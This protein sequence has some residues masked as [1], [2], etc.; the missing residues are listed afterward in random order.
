[1][2]AAKEVKKDKEKKDKKEKKEKKE[3]KGKSEKDD[4]AVEAAQAVP[5]K[6]EPAAN[7]DSTFEAFLESFELGDNDTTGAKAAEAAEAAKAEAQAEEGAPAA[8]F[9]ENSFWEALE[10]MDQE[11]EQVPENTEAQLPAAT[12]T[13]GVCMLPVSAE[14]RVELC[15]KVEMI[16]RLSNATLKLGGSDSQALLKIGGMARERDAA[17]RYAQTILARRVTTVSEHPDLTLLSVSSEWLEGWKEDE[18]LEQELGVLI[19]KLDETLVRGSTSKIPVGTIVEARY[20]KGPRWFLAS[21]LGSDGPNAITVRWHIDSSSCEVG[22]KEIR[23]APQVG[24]FGPPRARLA[25]EVRILA[26]FNH[27]CKGAIAATL[28]VRPPAGD[29]GLEVVELGIPYKSARRLQGNPFVA[30]LLR[31]TGLPK[32]AEFFLTPKFTPGRRW[33]EPSVLLAGSRNQRWL[34][35]ALLVAFA[36]SFAAHEFQALPPA[37]VGDA[38][39][40][41]VPTVVMDEINGRRC[42]NMLSLMDRTG[43]FI[44]PMAQKR[45]KKREVSEMDDL[46]DLLFENTRKGDRKELAVFGPLRNRY[47]AKIAIM[48]SIE[49]KVPGFHERGPDRDSVVDPSVGLGVDIVWLNKAFEKASQLAA[50]TECAADAAGQIVLLAGTAEE[51]ARAR[52]YLKMIKAEEEGTE[53][54]DLE[55][56]NDVVTLTVPGE[57]SSSK[58]LASQWQKFAEETKTLAFYDGWKGKDGAKRIVLLGSALRQNMARLD[59]LHE[60]R[61]RI[62][63]AQQLLLDKEKEET[64]EGQDWNSWGGDWSGGWNSSSWPGDDKEKGGKGSSKGDGGRRDS[65]ASGKGDSFGSDGNKGKGKGKGKDDWDEGK[66]KGKGD[67][68]GFKAKGKGQLNF[69]N[70]GKGGEETKTA[71]A[72]ADKVGVAPPQTPAGPVGPAPPRTPGGPSGVA[73]PMTPG[74]PGIFVAPPMTPALPGLAAPFTPGF[75]PTAGGQ[76]APATP[77]IPT[78]GGDPAKARPEQPGLAAREEPPGPKPKGFRGAPPPAAARATRVAVAPLLVT[79]G[80]DVAPPQTPA[81]R[82]SVAPPGT[83]ALGFGAPPPQTPAFR[84]SVGVAPP[85]TPAFGGPPASAWAGSGAPPPQTP[86]FAGGA[87]GVVPPQTPAFGA[88]M[89]GLPPP[90]TPGGLGGPLRPVAGAPAPMTPAFPGEPQAPSELSQLLDTLPLQPKASAPAP[91]TPAVFVSSL[92]QPRA[93]RQQA[94]PYG[95]GGVVPMTPARPGAQVVPM[96]PARPGGATSSAPQTPAAI[97]GRGRLG[98][99]G[100]QTPAALARRAAPQTPAAITGGAP[101]GTF[102]PMTPAAIREDRSGAGAPGTPAALLTPRISALTPGAMTPGLGTMA[103][104]AATPALPPLPSAPVEPR[105]EEAAAEQASGAAPGGTG[106]SQAVADDTRSI[107]VGQKFL[108]VPSGPPPSSRHTPKAF[109][110]APPPAAAKVAASAKEED[111]PSYDAYMQKMANGRRPGP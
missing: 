50:A 95:V 38:L 31:A 24:I 82:S 44:L 35:G 42:E 66:G 85:M 53:L 25:A 108:V 6:A 30:Q 23:R 58:R 88:A 28:R 86:A 75:Q 5:P 60:A 68:F 96:T 9:N 74:A 55:S 97:A 41:S 1:M 91:A 100:P 104:A 80:E 94:D 71:S 21:M 90:Q 77:A 61:K 2:G 78:M 17:E 20:Q 111:F 109:R 22:A 98:S 101:S 72:A 18:K 76:A 93:E 4:M 69:V 19:V 15:R 27:I 3:K 13:D 40:V 10:S 32:A 81:F 14:G 16:A 63:E 47:H 33:D 54:L 7:G 43:S 70:T 56:Q 62:E 37:L 26:A 36:Q 46:L 49:K 107:L 45:G 110:G 51:R 79:S 29:L 84:S 102:Q 87:S 105:R 59:V 11:E 99:P 67:G 106:A 64:W 34:T 73:P 8:T 83:P 48:A 12:T 39:V 103:A 57:V 92:D 52:K 65:I 89:G